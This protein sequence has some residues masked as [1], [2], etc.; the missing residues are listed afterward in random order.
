MEKHTITQKTICGFER[1]LTENEKAALTIEKYIHEVRLLM[2]HL[3][4]DFISKS[5]LLHYRDV[6]LEKN[7]AR[8][9]NAKFSAINSYLEYAGLKECNYEVMQ[10]D[11]NIFYTAD[12]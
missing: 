6:L 4:G 9:V 7:Q 3:A 1:H 12:A 2:E 11:G 5:A 10:F 8:T